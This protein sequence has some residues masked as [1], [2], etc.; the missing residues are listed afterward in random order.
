MKT[1]MQGLAA[2]ALAFFFMAAPAGAETV[3]IAQVDASPLLLAQNVDLYLSITD[4]TGR[5]VSGLRMEDFSVLESLDGEHYSPV[6][7]VRSLTERPHGEEG[8]YILLLVDN[9]GSMYDSM[10]G[11]PTED[12]AE[13]RTA[14]ARG[15]ISRFVGSSFNRKD[16]IALASFNTDVTFHA[17]NVT[18]PASVNG[19]LKEIRRPEAK[20]AYTELYHALAE[21]AAPA[22]TTRGRRVVVVLSDGENY[23]YYTRSG[24]PHPKY[25]T[26]LLTPQEV[27]EAYQRE[28]VTLYAINFGSER[29]RNLGDMAL[30]TG[31]AVYD[32]R[33]ED[34][35]AGIYRDI[36]E[37][38][39]SEYRLRYRAGMFASD[40]TFVRVVPRGSEAGAVERYYYTST[41][42]GVPVDPYPLRILLLL[43]LALLV[44]L[45]LFLVRYR[46]FHA[47]AALQVLRTGYGTK[48]S[49]STIALT[50][51]VTVIGGGERADLTISGRGA[52]RDQDVTI[53]YDRNSGS[54]TI[55]GG[56]G[57]T[58]NNRPVKGGRPLSGGDVLNIEGTT[59]VFEEPDRKK[60]GREKRT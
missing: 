3:S 15:A 1:G 51:D 12:E 54:Y 2:A 38:I 28:G 55:A 36:R 60:E 17:D 19:L 6:S 49:S 27:V 57:I 44:W 50:G 40:R 20:Q 32:A 25:G 33:N 18:D 21:A 29:D 14:Y 8:I 45:L 46:R 56:A 7:E 26:R 13:M 52:P 4:E 35:L 24:D 23:P 43:P 37:K 34:E 22:G 42:F 31:G 30:R 16:R 39:E 11:V 53:Q 10:S 59:I 47:A 9:S 58:V 48:V 41:M 5:P